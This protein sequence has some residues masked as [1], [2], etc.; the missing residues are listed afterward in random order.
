MT[1]LG[2]SDQIFS[3]GEQEED[4]EEKLCRICRS[5]EEPGNAL[6]HPCSCRGSIK[7]VHHDCL[8]IWLNRRGYKQCE[9]CGRSY[10]YVP[11]YSENAPE[12]LPC[13]EFL[14]EVL[15]RAVKLIVAWLAVMLLNTYFVSFHPWAQQLAAAHSR[16]D[17]WMSRRLAYWH[18]GLLYSILVVSFMTMMTTIM[19][20]EVGDVDVRRFG[21]VVEVLWKHMTILCVWYHRKLGRVFGQPHRPIVLPQNAEV[22]EFGVIRELLFFLDD[23]AFAL[24]AISVYVSTLFVLLPVWIGWAVLATVGGSFLFGNSPVTLGYVTLLSTC[25][26]YFTLPLIP[27]PAIVRWVSLGVHFTALKLPCLLWAFSVKSCKALQSQTSFPAI[28]K[29][30]SLGFHYIAVILPPLLWIFIK[31]ASVLCFKIGVVPWMIGY[32]LEICTSPLFGTSFF[33]RFETLSDFPGMTTLRWVAGTLYLFVAESFMKRIQEIVHKRAFWYLVDV[34]DP[35]YDI[36]KMNFA[37]TL[38]ALASHCV[39]LVIMFHLPIRAITL[40]SPSFFPLVLWV[41]DEKV[42]LGARFVYFRLLTS[43]PKWL[44]GLTKPA[45]EL[46]VQ[47]WVITVSSWLEL[48]D[49]LLVAPRGEDLDQNVRPVM[50]PRSFLLF[51]SLAEGSMVTLHGSQNDED[52]VKDQRDNR[53]LL[54]IVLMLML[55]ALSLFIVST[56]FMALPILLGR[57]FLEFISSL[58]LRYFGLKRDD[59]CAFWIG[60][61]TLE[62]IYTFTCFAYDQIHKGRIDVLLRDIR[63]G[64]LFFIWITV[65][66]GLLGLL[67]DLMIII[68]TRVPLDESPV[69]FLFQDWLIGVVVLHIWALL[70]MLTPINWFATKALR[71]KFERIRTV[72]IDRLPSMWLLREVIGSIA[73]TLLITLSFPYLLVKYLIPLLGYQESV[74]SAVE[75]FIWPAL[76]ALVAVWF[77]VKLT[78]EVVIYVHQLVFNERYMVGERVGNLA[79]ED[80]E[81]RCNFCVQVKERVT[82]S[83]KARAQSSFK[84]RRQFLRIL[85]KYIVEHQE[86]ICE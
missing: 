27:F 56:A 47:K 51:C 14:I 11:V 42:S 65:V 18:P 23:D 26:A 8:L 44:I 82:L 32:W 2:G 41:M 4:G 78:R 52:D 63:N 58:M 46:L 20:T 12:R 83:R 62:E 43:S 5:A 59:L 80:I 39:S 13:K 81:L 16:N 68:P 25:F 31:E 77:M 24:L 36:T 40:I 15:L 70:T 57:V 50:Q 67:I 79:E 71:R 17:S 53:F 75:R 48:S 21:R 76:F 84:V 60:Y 38:F 54:R 22:H 3:H 49:F 33:L 10:S 64:L 61:S 66:P 30:F 72:G 37:Y 28:V 35:D 6:M 9:V 73:I 1:Q 19:V 74:N 34:T 45:V 55:A 7:Y 69:Y 86:L 29:W 85:L